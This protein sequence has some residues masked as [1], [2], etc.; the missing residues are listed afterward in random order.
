MIIESL[1]IGIVVIV[2]TAGYLIFEAMSY[3]MID[4]VLG[5]CIGALIMH[6]GWAIVMFGFGGSDIL[7]Y[8]TLDEICTEL[9]G[10]LSEYN[11]LETT[12]HK[13]IC[14]PINDP[15]DIVLDDGAIVLRGYENE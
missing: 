15:K 14:N 10:E 5:I 12:K 11:K 3:K 9:S 4:I 6:I 1:I 13:L 8:E 2:V 7:S